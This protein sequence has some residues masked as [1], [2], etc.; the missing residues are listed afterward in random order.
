MSNINWHSGFVSA[1]KLELIDNIKDLLFEEEHKIVN[2]ALRIDLLIIKND[3]FIDIHNPIGTIFRRFNIC[4]YKGPGQSL[5]YGS[6]YKTLAYTCLYL[7]ETP[8]YDHMCTA[9][10]T[11]TFVREA[12]PYDLF[13]R[14]AADNVSI[15]QRSPGI[16]NLTNCLPFRTQVIITSEIPGELRSWLSTLTKHG[17][18]DNLNCILENTIKLDKEHKTEADNIMNIF[19]S[20]NNTFVKDKIRKEP[21]MC[22]AVNE[23][24][25]DEIEDLKK[26]VADQ[27][28]QLADIHSRLDDKDALIAQLRAE[29]EQLKRAASAKTNRG[30]RET[31]NRPIT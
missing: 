11:M 28:A 20:A 24:F 4:E 6:F 27:S 16:Y 8:K 10:Y 22:K 29:N 23:L 3:K 7:N 18:D 2:G 21:D 9:D 19:T 26:I 13:K 15:K 5:T 1:M 30:N 14:L 17:T 12:H 25:A 31:N